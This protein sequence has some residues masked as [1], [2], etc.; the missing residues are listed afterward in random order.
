MYSHHKK[1]ENMLIVTKLINIICT[2][3]KLPQSYLF[4]IPSIEKM[5]HYLTRYLYC[6][7]KITSVFTDPLNTM[8]WCD[9][10]LPVSYCNAVFT[11]L[12]GTHSQT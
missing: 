10:Q 7:E 5:N 2:T 4:K 9:I 12:A 11:F 8:I 6:I 1:N 3:Y